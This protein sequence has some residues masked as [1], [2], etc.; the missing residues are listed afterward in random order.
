MNRKDSSGRVLKTGEGQRDNGTYQYRYKDAHGVR[1]T[2]YAKTLA[3]L[4]VKE[5]DIERHVAGK[6]VY[7]CSMKLHELISLYIE[8]RKHSVKESTIVNMKHM[9]SSLHGSAIIDM[10]IG[11]IKNVHVRQWCM[12][13]LDNNSSRST[14]SLK[15]SMMRCAFKLAMSDDLVLKNPFDFNINSIAKSDEVQRVPLNKEDQVRFYS[16][17]SDNYSVKYADIYAVI[18][19][20]GLRIS[21]L[22]A[23]TV[24]DIDFEN[25]CISVNKQ[26]VCL[27]KPTR[28]CI[29]STKSKAGVR[30]VPINSDIENRLRS[31]IYGRREN[32]LYSTDGYTNFL[33]VNNKGL[34][35]YKSIDMMFQIM[36]DKYNEL[37]GTN[38][39]VSPH[40][41]RHTY[42]TNL[43]TAGIDLKALSYIMGHKSINI[44]QM[45]YDHADATRAMEAYTKLTP[46]SCESVPN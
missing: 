38:I 32:I 8:T 6:A 18:L 24:D 12:Q 33:F 41:L 17:V 23:L 3:E 15:L 13:E 5:K 34:Y 22:L 16:F 27:N 14:V 25:H 40:V 10:N 4:R 37:Y 28:V 19:G 7:N 42:C 21:E 45:V 44:T 43:S 2:V 39:K 29:S 20:T 1:K 9:L 26:T 36:T 30:L 46:F 31:I 11:D 35:K